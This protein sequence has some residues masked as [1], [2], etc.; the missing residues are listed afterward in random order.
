MFS[1]V[2]ARGAG[3]AAGTDYLMS[4]KDAQGKERNI[5]AEV[6]RGDPRITK[7]I[8]SRL[9]FAQNYKSGV[10]SFTETVDEI[11]RDKLGEIM[12]SFEDMVKAGFEDDPGRID[13]LWVLHQDKGRAELHWVIPNV[14]LETG[15]RFQP[16]FDR[17]DQKMF[18]AWERLTNTENGFTDPADPARA[19]NINIPAY[20][21]ENKEAQYRQI[22]DAIVG[23]FAQG[24]IKNRDDVVKTL[25]TAG[26]EINRL[27]R[28]YLSIKDPNGLKLRLKGAFYGESFRSPASLERHAEQGSGDQP[29]RLAELRGELEGYVAKRRDYIRGRYCPSGSG[30]A[31]R[32]SGEVQSLR[33]APIGAVSTIGSLAR[34]VFEEQ[35]YEV[36][37]LQQEGLAVPE[38]VVAGGV[39]N[40]RDVDR[41]RR[42]DVGLERDDHQTAD[43]GTATE[44][45]RTSEESRQPPTENRPAAA[46]NQE[47]ELTD[48]RTRN[49]AVTV[50]GTTEQRSPGERSPF[51]RAIE[52]LE[53]EVQ[54]IDQAST[55]LDS[56]TAGLPIVRSHL[57]RA[58]RSAREIGQGIQSATARNQRTSAL[59]GE[60]TAGSDQTRTTIQTNQQ[61]HANIVRQHQEVQR[62]IELAAE[63]AKEKEEQAKQKEELARDLKLAVEEARAK[64]PVVKVIKSRSQGHG[65]SM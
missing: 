45:Q 12:D 47:E 60:F 39:G 51:D 13:V 22:N 9:N 20:L 63:R 26:Y 6:L 42:V 48:D 7:Q 11:G 54:R 24:Q 53:H 59:L 1:K 17:V 29:E 30:G 44:E 41:S 21:P 19:R 10:L 57:Q 14:D 8:I 49:N 58:G 38:I 16:Y 5:P 36:R 50:P 28:D 3:K 61:H 52:R 34:P 43:R 35:E 4:E 33:T 62:L 32:S 25:T 18:R 55:D 40:N 65:H 23:L 31:E 64:A 46:E 2:F 56:R 27:S 37:S 15:K